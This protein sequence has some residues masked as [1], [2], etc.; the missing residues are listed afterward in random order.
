MPKKRSPLDHIGAAQS[1]IFMDSDKPDENLVST[2]EALKSK[3]T[4]AVVIGVA[5]LLIIGFI[6]G[7]VLYLR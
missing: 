4:K 5:A 3:S 7:M 2:E 1:G 6:V